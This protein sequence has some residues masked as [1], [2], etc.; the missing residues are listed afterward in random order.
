MPLYAPS[1]IAW[2]RQTIDFIEFDS[3]VAALASSLHKAGVHCKA[4]D[5][6][7]RREFEKMTPEGFKLW[8]CSLMHVVQKKSVWFATQC[9][10]F[11]WM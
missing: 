2:S 8:V 4:F 6:L 1:L 9:S 10:S 5:K 3:G 7:Y 11:S